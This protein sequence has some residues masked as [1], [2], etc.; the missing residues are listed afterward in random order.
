M[1]TSN[2]IFF[3]SLVCF[4]VFAG[5]CSNSYST[6]IIDSRPALENSSSVLT[7]LDSD[8]IHGDIQILG[9]VD[10]SR[11]NLASC[12]FK[13]LDP[14]IIDFVKNSGGNAIIFN[15]FLTGNKTN[16]PCKDFTADIA[17][18]DFQND[19]LIFDEDSLLVNW[20]FESDPLEGIYESIGPSL[21][22]VRLGVIKNSL[23]NYSLLHY[24]E[25]ADTYN[26]IWKKGNIK[27]TLN[28]TGA[29]NTFKADWINENRTI[30]H[31]YIISFQ[32]GIMNLINSRF[33]FQQSFLKVSPI[34]NRVNFSSATGFAISEKG[35][36]ATNYH[37][38]QN[39]RKITVRGVAGNFEKEYTAKIVLEDSNNDLAIIQIEVPDYEIEK[40]PY[41]LKK[42]LA[43]VG[44]EVFTL[45]YPLR[46]S[47]GDEIKLTNGV[48]SSKTGFRGDVTLYQTS[49][50]TEPGN[51]G[52]PLFDS[53]G[54]IIGVISS[55]HPSAQHA[56]YAVKSNYLATLF[57]LLPEQFL[58]Q[59][60]N[61]T[62]GL[63]VTEHIKKLTP[64][65]YIIE[66]D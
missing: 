7:Y 15:R 39:A 33:G 44:E 42:S 40:I 1:L 23:N 58:P 24:G 35:Y 49:T 56:T 47:M 20:E 21:R 12:N 5:A 63:S 17:F 34:N 32:N 29:S 37:V 45:G 54:R 10:V 38:V 6:K 28:P 61:E 27:G 19:S 43:D 55:K 46:S 18:I 13:D 3:T 57:E 48:V 16:T 26:H 31:N 51:S 11:T 60:D 53:E 64:F 50:A 52:G 14:E 25:V 22:D 59:I 4:F 62:S 2:R 36:I 66:I 41:T 8:A 65:I 30:S 9:S